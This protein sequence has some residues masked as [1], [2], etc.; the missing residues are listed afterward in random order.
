L[1][2]RVESREERRTIR[3]PREAISRSDF[4]NTLMGGFIVGFVG[5]LVID[6]LRPPTI[7]S[8]PTVEG[9]AVAAEPVGTMVME[10]RIDEPHSVIAAEHLEAALSSTADPPAWLASPSSWGGRR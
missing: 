6:W 8:S 5:A 10:P 4:P 2:D 9:Q 7:E 3:P 1:V